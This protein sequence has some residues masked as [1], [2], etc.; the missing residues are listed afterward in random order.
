MMRYIKTKTRTY[1]DKD[2]T[3]L[4]D[5]NVSDNGVEGDSLIIISIESLLVYGNKYY[6]QVYL[7][8]YRQTNDR[9]S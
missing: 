7:D 2:N 3:S 4:L 5:L 1:D 6:P 8:N 9:L